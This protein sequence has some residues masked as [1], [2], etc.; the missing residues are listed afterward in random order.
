[1]S[2][3][4]CPVCHGRLSDGFFEDAGEGSRGRLRW[5]PGPI[6]T[7]ALGGTRRFG[8]ERYDVTAYRCESCG[9][10]EMYVGGQPA[11]PLPPPHIPGVSN[12]PDR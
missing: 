1:V 9:R 10:L 4:T 6:E 5:I 12:E 8:K 3:F 2:A 7:G 11:A